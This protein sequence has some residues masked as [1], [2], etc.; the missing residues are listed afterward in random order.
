[1]NLEGSI[2]QFKMNKDK[3]GVAKATFLKYELMVNYKTDDIKKE[4]CSE[5]CSDL[6]LIGKNL[7]EIFNFQT[8]AESILI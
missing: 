8:L 2:K 6:E 4:M 5:I 3:I 7:D 1:M